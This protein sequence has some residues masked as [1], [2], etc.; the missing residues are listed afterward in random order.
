MNEQIQVWLE[1]SVSDFLIL[2]SSVSTAILSV[3]WL[4]D[5][6][7]R[8]KS[9]A[10]AYRIWLAAFLLV[11]FVPVGMSAVPKW[12]IM[13]PVPEFVN[14]QESTVA[15]TGANSI[16]FHSI[17]T[18]ARLPN[19][20][21][22]TS[23]DSMYPPPP[24]TTRLDPK[25]DTH[26]E[27]AT[28][29]SMTTS[30]ALGWIV[31]ALLLLIRQLYFHVKV[32]VWRYGSHPFEQSFPCNV[33]VRIGKSIDIPITT[34]IVRP[35][36]L[37]PAPARRWSPQRIEL[38]LR[39]ELAHV[40]R[41]DV[42]WN[43]LVALIKSLFW[44]QPLCWIGHAKMSLEREQ[45][46]DDAVIVD[47]SDAK[48][49]A[50]EL[51]AIMKELVGKKQA[52]KPSGALAIS[53]PPMVTRLKS[54][55]DQRNRRDWSIG[56]R[57]FA[58]ILCLFIAC[59]I[60]IIRPVAQSVTA[61]EKSSVESVE[62]MPESNEDVVQIP[63]TLTG[64]L[65]DPAGNPVG[66]G[67]IKLG[68]RRQPQLIQDDFFR[69]IGVWETTS[70]D[71]GV[72]RISIPEGHRQQSGPIF[73]SMHI[74]ADGFVPVTPFVHTK[75][76]VEEGSLG[77]HELALGR[78]LTGKIVKPDEIPY[79]PPQNASIYLSGLSDHSVDHKPW[80]SIPVKCKPDGSFQ[81][82]VPRSGQLSYVAS[83]KNYAPMQG[84]FDAPADFTADQN[85][86][87]IA[88]QRGSILFGKVLDENNKPLVG[89][90]VKLRR[91]QQLPSE[92]AR[93]AAMLPVHTFAK[94]DEEGRYQFDYFSGE[95]V[96]SLVRSGSKQ[97]GFFEGIESDVEPPVVVPIEVNL[98][99]QNASVYMN[100]RPAKTVTISGH[101]SWEDHKP[102]EGV[103]IRG[104][105]FLGGGYGTPVSQTVTDA[106]GNYSIE[107]PVDAE[108]HTLFAMGKTIQGKHYSIYPTDD[109][110]AVQKSSQTLVL[111]NT[112]HDQTGIDWVFKDISQVNAKAKL[113]G[114]APKPPSS[115]ANLKVQPASFPGGAAYLSTAD[116]ELL[117]I[118]NDYNTGMNK[119]HGLYNNVSTEKQKQE[120]S[121]RQAKFYAEI[122]NR[123]FEFETKFRGD[124]ASVNA[125]SEILEK[126]CN[127]V[128]ESREQKEI[129]TAYKRAMETL[130]SHYVE[131]ENAW[132]AFSSFE[133]A[134]PPGNYPIDFVRNV[135]TKN[136]FPLN[137]CY[138]LYSE[139]RY[140][141]TL[142]YFRDFL[143]RNNWKTNWTSENDIDYFR[144]LDRS[145]TVAVI[146]KKIDVIR[147]LYA[148]LDRLMEGQPQ[149][150]NSQVVGMPR[151]GVSMINSFIKRQIKSSSIDR[152]E[153][154]FTEL[155]HNIDFKV[156]QLV[157]GQPFPTNYWND[158]I[159]K[160][161][162]KSK[163]QKILLLA[164]FTYGGNE[165]FGKTLMRAKTTDDLK[166]IWLRSG[167]ATLNSSIDEL[168][169]DVHVIYD[170]PARSMAIR[171]SQA[172]TEAY[173]LIDENGI[174][175]AIDIDLAGIVDQIETLTD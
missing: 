6:L 26:S 59:S 107:M 65:V 70:D 1:S 23:P 54:I 119:F 104:S 63:E 16:P 103:A 164:T 161:V 55:L 38:V 57:A 3:A 39:H 143:E 12:K 58:W 173:Y 91:K 95:C 40:H 47:G 13:I 72:F 123:L 67:K 106:S 86:G 122:C 32:V 66:G 68:I 92:P 150:I 158:E 8:R 73:A 7:W 90:V 116:R 79:G 148:G 4:I 149:G 141:Y 18:L 83:A 44:F 157:I 27:P 102:V 160:A 151:G 129:K 51:V 101:V 142:L 172:D 114:T 146:N 85:V 24:A 108:H 52:V 60:S 159:E 110:E 111:E 36:I 80:Y 162:S 48:K 138:A 166:I 167:N 75:K 64:K 120:L 121:Q 35:M 125:I 96:M 144:K 112:K 42:F 128:G 19:E 76:M 139:A 25:R 89:A 41:Q 126:C 170:Q 34:G 113:Y 124:V 78:L 37:F 31:V 153:I 169:R 45:A 17:D 100:I 134:F 71:K 155:T 174:L 140:L 127:W 62:K 135:Q 56:F 28:S 130:N 88:L 14:K 30:L 46:C 147:K 21:F 29:I 50:G 74:Q 81:C 93:I 115:S 49:Y 22:T 9:A 168:I 97:N 131:N 20:P 82:Y 53:E 165:V 156:N 133:N 152:Q 77:Q 118:S 163:G 15:R 132:L 105:V 2:V 10:V 154:P 84:R 99:N 87:D 69:R 61:N 117:K 5:I 136:P 33:P 94:T 171:W 109:Y 98:G 175:R 11:M 43:S 137:R 145:E